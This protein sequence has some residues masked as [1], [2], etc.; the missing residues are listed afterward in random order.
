MPKNEDTL[1]RQWHMLRFVPRHPRKITVRAIQAKL[2]AEGFEVS[3]RT[4]QRDL[5]ELSEVFPLTVDDREK[6]FGWSW[7]K[8]AN[9]FDL[10]GIS[11][12]EALTWVMA[13]QNLSK[14]LPGSL[15]EHL[16][17]HFRAAHERLEKEPQPQRGR[18]WLSKVRCVTASQPLIPP[19]IDPDVQAV[20]SDAVMQ[21]R[22]VEIIYR[23]KGNSEI[24]TYQVH[25][26]AIVQRGQ[27][28]Y[29]YGRLFN[30][31][32]TRILAMHRIEAAKLLEQPSIPPDNFDLDDK[33]AKGVWSFGASD[34]INVKF[35]F[36]NGCGEHL[37]E[38]PLSTNQRS[39]ADED[40]PKAI[41]VFATIV[42]TP[43][44]RWWLLGFGDGVEVLEPATLRQELTE[45]AQKIVA[46]YST[47]A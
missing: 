34:Q 10:P 15:L 47:Q 14:L 29:L 2:S 19:H 11:V 21:E 38:T 24:S 39:E 35:K 28:I 1:F 4:V 5:M 31:P 36:F 12:A 37:L 25:P 22:Q 7:H 18:K 43:Q 44:L 16:A 13:E 26:L 46:R 27:V 8:D 33:V 6:P 17:P 30:Y 32:N 9:A 23:T 41:T 3:D 20:I 45:T 40:D 42:D